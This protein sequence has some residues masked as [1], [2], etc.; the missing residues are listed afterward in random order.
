MEIDNLEDTERGTWGFGSSDIGPKGILTCEELKVKM[1]F[2]NSDTQ[3]NSYFDEEDIHTHASLLDEVTMLSSALI[4]AIQMQTMDDSFL[5]RIRAGGKED[6]SW[7]ARKGE[8]SQLKEKQET[9][10]THCELEDG[11]LYYKGRLFIPSKEE[12]RTEVAKGCHHSTVAGHF[13]Q[14]KSIQLV[15][16]N[17][18]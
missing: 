2:L 3:A 12:L 4:V 8:F 16:R 14:E 7:T 17:F 1:Y 10:A 13:G 6:D 15:T 9:Q 5:D 11:P 18:R